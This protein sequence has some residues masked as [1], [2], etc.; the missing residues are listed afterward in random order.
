MPEEDISTKLALSVNK[1]G[2]GFVGGF[3]I[4]N[5]FLYEAM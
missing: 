5:A 1:V 2:Y 3:H 4:K